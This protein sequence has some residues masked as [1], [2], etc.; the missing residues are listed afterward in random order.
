MAPVDTSSD[1]TVATKPVTPKKRKIVVDFT[2][3]A[4]PQKPAAGKDGIYVYSEVSPP[5]PGGQ[6][7]IEDYINNHIEYPQLAL[8][9]NTEGRAGIS[10]VVNEDGKISDAHA[11]GKPLGE[12]LD[13]EAV[14]VIS[15]MPNWTPGTVKGKRVKTRMTLP[16][17]FEIQE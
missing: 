3:V 11:M 13:E 14:K 4:K 17:V 12:G 2:P 6:S 10:F 15:A 16:I 1:A 8:D 7:A 5:F 9:N